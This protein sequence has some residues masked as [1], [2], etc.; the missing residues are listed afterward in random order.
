MSDFNAAVEETAEGKSKNKKEAILEIVVVVMLGITAICT[1]WASWVGALH[2]GNQATNYT[3][4]NNLAAEANSEYNVA[5]QSELTDRLV[6]NEFNDLN[7]DYTYAE[8]AGDEAEIERLLWKLTELQENSFSEELLAAYLWSYD[9]NLKYADDPDVPAVTPFDKEDYG[10]T[11]YESYYD[12]EAQSKAALEQ[13]QKDNSDGDAFGLVT[14][15]YSVVLFLLGIC[16]SFKNLRN[17]IAIA[18]ISCV[19]FVA[20]TVYMFT[21]SMP[22]GFSLA[23]FFG[24]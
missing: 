13:G 8:E 20:A 9:E 18:S 16:G 5:V 23:S 11:Y 22:T 3:K 6:Y 24:G 14:V 4:S 17:K 7:I 19:A 1:A 10:D 21:I 15:I 2:G 12:L